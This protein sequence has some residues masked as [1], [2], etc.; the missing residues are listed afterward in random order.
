MESDSTQNW[1]DELFIH[2]ANRLEQPW[3]ASTVGVETKD[4]TV[5][6]DVKLALW[7]T[8]KPKN[9]TLLNIHICKQCQIMKATLR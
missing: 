2:S 3:R 5:N 7:S 6:V 4:G 1:R 9:A 8:S